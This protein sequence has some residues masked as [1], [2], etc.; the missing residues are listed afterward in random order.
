LRTAYDVHTHRVEVNGNVGLVSRAKKASQPAS[1]IYFLLL[2]LLLLVVV[3]CLLRCPRNQCD[4]RCPVCRYRVLLFVL[5][6]ATIKKYT[7]S[8]ARPPFERSVFF[9]G[10]VFA[11]AARVH[12]LKGFLALLGPLGVKAANFAPNARPPGQPAIQP[13][14]QPASQPAGPIFLAPNYTRTPAR[15]EQERTS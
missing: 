10:T 5:F 3:V 15:R 12:T 1:Q 11:V 6:G 7:E 2:H 9:F 8:R 14:S 4:Q 13:P